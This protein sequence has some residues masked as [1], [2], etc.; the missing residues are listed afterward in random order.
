MECAMTT[1][2]FLEEH[3]ARRLSDRRLS[4][5]RRKWWESQRL[6]GMCEA[7]RQETATAELKYLQD[8]LK[9][10]GGVEKM[11]RLIAKAIPT[12]FRIVT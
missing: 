6:H 9:T 4:K 5:E 3:R 10:S 1:V 2:L 11:K 12:E 7:F 8:R